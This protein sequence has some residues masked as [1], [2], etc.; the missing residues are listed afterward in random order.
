MTD[1]T[2]GDTFD[3]K[4]TT[5][6]FSTGVPTTLAGTPSVAAYPDNSVTEITTGI[7]L[8]VD[9]DAR[10]GLNNVRIV[11]TGG[12]G[13]ASGS[14]YS[15][16]ITAG[17]VGGTSV[18]GEVV[19]EFTLGRSA[20]AVDLANGT[21]GLGAIKG[22][23]AAIETDTQDIQGRLPATLVGGRIDSNIGA[24]S[25][26]VPAA[27][28][29]ELDYDGTGYNKSTSTIGTCT[30]NTD[31][32]GTDNAALASVATEARL[33]E[34]DAA[35]LPTDIDAILVDTGTTL[36]GALVTIQSDTDDIQTRLPATLI[37]GRM[38]SDVEAINDNTLAAVRLAL[39]MGSIVTGQAQAGTLSITQMT[40]DLT[41][42][43]TDHYVG[44]VIIWTSGALKDQATD[45]TAYSGSGGLL[46]YTSV[47][48]PPIANDTFIII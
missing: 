15:L 44:R 4:F 21:D 27:D 14:T 41:E 40:T 43:T 5:R 17:T 16:V 29:L 46:T 31:M 37:N 8:S 42:A 7:T 20:A 23:T 34:L 30:T 38:N 33:S 1:Y 6:A 39:T 18:V 45:I 26:D 2:L 28:N 9:F 35:N 11:A 36:P 47:T 19:G 22:Q 10:T 12:N 3:I 48:E 13:Y 32:R 24:I 25:G